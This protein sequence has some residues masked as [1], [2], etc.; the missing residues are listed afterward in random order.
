MTKKTTKAKYKAKLFKQEFN[1]IKEIIN[2][3]GSSNAQIASITGWS[4]SLIRYI[5]RFDTYEDYQH[6]LK[7]KFI[8]KSEQIVADKIV[9]DNNDLVKIVNLLENIDN[10]LKVLAEKADGRKDRRWF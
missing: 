5:R 1:F 10:S 2:N 8:K 9:N 4:T 7:V 3:T 6:F